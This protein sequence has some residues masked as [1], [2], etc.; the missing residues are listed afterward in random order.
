M[1]FND[2]FRL[3]IVTING[4][5]ELEA[6]VQFTSP[7]IAS[8]LMFFHKYNTYVYASDVHYRLYL[9]LMVF[10]L[11]LYTFQLLVIVTSMQLFITH[12]NRLVRYDDCR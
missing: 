8:A 3:R 11:Y 2:A 4:L 9:I 7:L 12:I 5:I 6:D 1:M 10:F